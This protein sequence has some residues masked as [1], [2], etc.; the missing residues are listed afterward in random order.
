MDVIGFLCVSL[1]WSTVQLHDS[2]G[3][4]RACICSE[5]GFSSQNGDRVSGC[6]TE[7]Q[8]SVVRFFLW[9]D[10]LDA[11]DIYKDMFPIYG[12]SV[13]NAKRFT[14]GSITFLKDV[15]KSQMMPHQ[16]RK[17]LRQQSKDFYATGFDA[18]VLI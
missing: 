11:K 5:A 4:R 9:A 13:C 1:V 16:V 18:L 7:E 6:T 10:G 17:W 8:G 12:G 2:S 3:S 15:R 14:T